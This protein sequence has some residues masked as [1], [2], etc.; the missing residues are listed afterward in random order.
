MF[1][2]SSPL[3]VAMMDPSWKNIEETEEIKAEFLDYRDG[4]LRHQD[5]LVLPPHT[6][7]ML[8][9]YKVRWS[10]PP[11]LT[12]RNFYIHLT[13][14]GNN[15]TQYLGSESNVFETKKYFIPVDLL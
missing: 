7:K 1:R 13:L 2:P 11:N 10:H 6:V 3:I 4:L 15:F 8:P 9:T 5:G 12:Q 14:W